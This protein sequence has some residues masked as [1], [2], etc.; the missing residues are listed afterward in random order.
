MKKWWTDGGQLFKGKESAGQS[1]TNKW[2][3][4]S[5]PGVRYRE[6]ETRKNGV[7]KDQYFIISYRIDVKRKDEAIGWASKGWTAKKANALL[8]E[9]LE[10]QRK[11]NGP[12]TLQEKRSLETDRREKEQERIKTQKKEALTISAFFD[13]KYIPASSHKKPYTMANEKR[14]FKLWIEPEIGRLPFSK[15]TAF[16]LEKIKKRMTDEGKSERTIQYCIA[17]VRQIWNCS[18]LNGITTTPFPKVKIKKFDNK[19]LRFFT[20]QESTALL[21]EL[22][23]RSKQLHDMALIS[24]HTGA[25]A[26]EIFALTWSS[27]DLKN[28]VLTAKDTKSGKT[29]FLYLTNETRAI[30]KKK[31]VGQAPQDLV[32]PDRNGEKIKFIS[33]SFNRALEKLGFNKDITDRRDKAS[34]HTLRHTFASWHAQNGTDLYTVK[35]LLGHS[36][37]ALTE[38]YSHLKPEGLKQTTALFNNIEKQSADNY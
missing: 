20:Q 22:K 33:A 25:R 27:V 8:S 38:R 36:T 14:L 32:F 9:I 30:F 35:E 28:D 17:I 16:N 6:H 1:M 10:N 11:G 29:R 18:R 34:F 31:F 37:I 21:S 2:E 4:T 19:R 13:D 5:F 26:G 15:I 3:K 23:T 12:Q 24:L 7:K